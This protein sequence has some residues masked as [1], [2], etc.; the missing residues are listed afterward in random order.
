[1]RIGFLGGTFNP[2]HNG[3]LHLAREWSGRLSL[4]RFLMTPTGTPPHKQPSEV[5]GEVRLE[6][7]RIAA[8]ESGGMLEAYDFEVRRS[9]QKSYS[10]V[11]LSALHEAFPGSDIFMVMGADMFLSLESWYDFDRLKTLATF[12]TVPRDGVSAEKLEAHRLHLR[13]LGCK[14][15]LADLPEMDIS[16]TEIRRRVS[17]GEPIYGLVPKGVEEYIYVHG[18]YSNQ[19][20]RKG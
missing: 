10:V 14:G 16:S 13:E 15:L 20:E 18:L 4:D 19:N 12:C 1:M 11:T 6:M 7:C 5:P 2:P 9:G 17:E 8:E 3:H